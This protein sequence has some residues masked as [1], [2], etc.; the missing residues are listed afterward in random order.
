MLKS[1]PTRGKGLLEA[2]HAAAPEPRAL[3]AGWEREDLSN[4]VIP[5]RGG[6]VVKFKR[7][8]WR[9]RTPPAICLTRHR[10]SSASALPP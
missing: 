2:H 3:G 9:R 6:G 10:V 1:G 8:P 4:G 5:L 7:A